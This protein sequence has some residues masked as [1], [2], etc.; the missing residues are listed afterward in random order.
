MRHTFT[1]STCV[2]G[3]GVPRRASPAHTRNTTPFILSHRATNASQT[4]NWLS[5]CRQK[6]KHQPVAVAVAPHAQLHPKPLHP[7]PPPPPPRRLRSAGARPRLM[8][9]MQSSNHPRSA[10]ALREPKQR[11]QLKPS[12]QSL[13]PPSALVA[14]VPKLLP[15]KK[16]LRQKLEVA[17]ANPMPSPPLRPLRLPSAVAALPR[18]LPPLPT[19]RVLSRQLLA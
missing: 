19:R 7:P 10:V 1:R 11:K 3:H 17:L 14:H 5:Q 13:H 4:I 18:H 2:L 16:P 8:Q 15:S 9:L 12:S 6:P